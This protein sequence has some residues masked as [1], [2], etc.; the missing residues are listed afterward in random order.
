[1]V[2]I[3]YI[4]ILLAGYLIIRLLINFSK[5]D[6]PLTDKHSS[7]EKIHTKKVSKKVGEYVDYE[8]IKKKKK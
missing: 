8:E 3:R 5:N 1:M 4:L 6:A 2:L 7:S